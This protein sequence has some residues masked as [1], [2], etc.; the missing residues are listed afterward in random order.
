MKKTFLFAAL[1]AVAT[2]LGCSES[3][4]D[5]TTPEVSSTDISI[6]PTTLSFDSGASSATVEVSTECDWVVMNGS[7]WI[8]AS[9]NTGSGSSTV[10]ISVTE[11]DSDSYRSTNI[12]FYTTY[13]TQVSLVVEQE[14][15]TSGGGGTSDE[16]FTVEIT[17]ATSSAIYANIDPNDYTGTWYLAPIE[18]MYY[19]EYFSS[20]EEMAASF[21]EM[22]LT[23]YYTDLTVVDNYY[24]FQGAYTNVN[25]LAGWQSSSN[26]EYAIAI[27][28]MD[29]SGNITTDITFFT[30]STASA[31]LTDFTLDCQFS[32]ITSTTADF[33]IYPSNDETYYIFSFYTTSSIEDYYAQG[34]TEDYLYEY[35]LDANTADDGQIYAYYGEFVT[36]SDGEPY[37]LSGLSA[38][39]DYCFVGYG[40]V[41]DGGYI[42][43]RC[44]DAQISEFSTTSASGAPAYSWSSVE[45]KFEVLSVNIPENTSKLPVTKK[46]LRQ[47]AVKGTS[48]N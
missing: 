25:L 47:I 43:G 39:S 2:L 4:E 36:N 35:V 23:Y 31:E 45:S 32:N 17:G 11:N 34:G 42:T 48:K 33:A 27:F 20:P 10:T 16:Q 1:L 28:G 29:A 30:T 26:T 8:S 24:V 18:Y 19:T 15:A 9:T 41:I 40:L 44:S 6:N 38:S 46:T 21:M 22:E 14:A 12:I 13:D 37:T 5:P 7:E 3:N